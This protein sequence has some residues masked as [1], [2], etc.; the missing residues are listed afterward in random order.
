NCPRRHLSAFIYFIK[1]VRPKVKEEN[2]NAT[3]EDIARLSAVAW[4]NAQPSV[5]EKYLKIALQD[6]QRWEREFKV[7]QQ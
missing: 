3:F 7:Y 6:K 1:D 4:E 5:R 2:P